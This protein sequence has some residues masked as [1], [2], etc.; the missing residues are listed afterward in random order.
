MTAPW[1]SI[2]GMQ[3]PNPNGARG[4]GKIHAMYQD[5]FVTYRPLECCRFCA[6]RL[7]EEAGKPGYRLPDT[8]VLCPH[9]RKRELDDLLARAVLNEVADLRMAPMTLQSGI[10]QVTVTWAVVQPSKGKARP[11]R[12]GR[13]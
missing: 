2:E 10:V 8:E 5:T 3:G 11:E 7:A 9:V 6:A 12:P 4:G 1:D 13:F